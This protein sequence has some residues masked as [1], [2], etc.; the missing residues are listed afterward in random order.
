MC[1]CVGTQPYRHPNSQQGDT[2]T[3]GTPRYG[4]L[5]FCRHAHR[6]E[7]LMHVK[8]EADGVS[9]HGPPLPQAPRL[10]FPNSQHEAAEAGSP[11]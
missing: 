8:R 10:L 5:L 7:D 3:V 4:Y 2:P 11:S 9:H 6:S 1:V